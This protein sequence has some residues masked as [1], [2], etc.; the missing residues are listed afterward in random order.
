MI[1]SV[2]INQKAYIYLSLWV[3]MLS[4]DDN[5]CLQKRH[6]DINVFGMVFQT[7]RKKKRQLRR[8]LIDEDLYYALITVEGYRLIHY[9]TG[10]TG[11]LSKRLRKVLGTVWFIWDIPFPYLKPEVICFTINYLDF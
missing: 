2:K 9:T 7:G 1:Y 10:Q 4:I 6:L 3:Q 5:I 11:Q 8:M